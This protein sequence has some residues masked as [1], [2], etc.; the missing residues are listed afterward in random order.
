MTSNASRSA[1]WLTTVDSLN[2]N[3]SIALGKCH[4]NIRQ[5]ITQ[6]KYE[7]GIWRILTD[8]TL[9]VGS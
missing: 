8:I 1:Q 7:V 6:G 2:F 4:V 3:Y 5:N 9:L